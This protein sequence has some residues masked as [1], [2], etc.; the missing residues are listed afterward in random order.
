MNLMEVMMA[1][2][3]F[4]VSAGSSMRVWS[5][6]S[7]G[8][9]QQRLHREQAELLE[10]ELASQ[11]AWLRQQAL[12]ATDLPVCGQGAERLVALLGRRPPRPGV[13]RRITRLDLE[14]GVLVEL[15]GE[16]SSLLRQRLYRPAALGMCLPSPVPSPLSAA[17]GGPDALA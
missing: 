14:D 8:E 4:S 9:A 13:Q 11:E 1:T 2:L 17:A 16:H 10:T 3:L 15:T 7:S 5:L 12:V 6:I